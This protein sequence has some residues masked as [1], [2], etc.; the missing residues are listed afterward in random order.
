[1][2]EEGARIRSIIF[3]GISLEGATG[4]L[5]W[6]GRGGPPND[7]GRIDPRI[8]SAEGFSEGGALVC[9]EKLRPKF[10]E[11]LELEA[12]I[13]AAPGAWAKGWFSW[14]SSCSA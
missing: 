13:P 9:S 12:T 6:G 11:G 5:I 1:M 2:P 14:L 4:G 10:R 7:S 8:S 3:L